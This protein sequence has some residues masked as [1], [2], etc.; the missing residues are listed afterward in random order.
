MRQPFRA[1]SL[2]FLLTVAIILAGGRPAYAQAVTTT[3]ATVHPSLLRPFA[4]SL[5]DIRHLGTRENLNWLAVGL[6]AAVAAHRADAGITRSWTEPGSRAF[7]PGAIVGGTPL[8][9]GAA[10]ATF[11]IGGQRTALA[12]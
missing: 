8:E 2:A 5:I 9:L 10:F 12:P 3:T 6:S 7:K 1:R 4:D 11:A